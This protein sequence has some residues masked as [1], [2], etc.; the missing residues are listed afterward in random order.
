MD[1]KQNTTSGLLLFTVMSVFPYGSAGERSEHKEA[2]DQ[3]C[4]FDEGL[5]FPDINI[6]GSCMGICLCHSELLSYSENICTKLAHKYPKNL[7][8]SKFP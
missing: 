2:S 5:G 8:Y 3:I 1:V 6:T 7:D 4:L